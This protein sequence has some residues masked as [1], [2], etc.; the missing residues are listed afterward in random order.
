MTFG[1]RDTT[2]MLPDMLRG[3]EQPTGFLPR[4]V[5]IV[6]NR[7]VRIYPPMGSQKNA[8]LPDGL[9]VNGYRILRKIASGGFSIVYLALTFLCGLAYLSVGMFWSSMT[10]DQIVQCL[11]KRIQIEFA[12]QS[13]RD[14]NVVNAVARIQLIQEPQPL[15]R[16]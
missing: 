1:L 9:T 5:H 13:H 10:R 14:R 8:P 16:P 11:L 12:F 4:G 6:S 15:L 2:L 3:V 7:T